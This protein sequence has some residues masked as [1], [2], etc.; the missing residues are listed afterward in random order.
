[1]S[2]Q[3]RLFLTGIPDRLSKTFTIFNQP[4]TLAELDKEID[5]E[6][7]LLLNDAG[8]SDDELAATFEAEIEDD[9]E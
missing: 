4:I 9:G 3:S 7:G 2:I 6:N 5:A 8:V 1:M